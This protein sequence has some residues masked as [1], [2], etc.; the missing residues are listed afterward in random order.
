MGNLVKFYHKEYCDDGVSKL[1]L[2]FV[3][4][5]KLTEISLEILD[6]DS[7]GNI[8]MLA[9]CCPYSKSKYN[10]IHML[11]IDNNINEVTK[12]LKVMYCFQ[13][14]DEG[15]ERLLSDGVIGISLNSAVKFSIEKCYGYNNIYPDLGNMDCLSGYKNNV[16]WES[17]RNYGLDHTNCFRAGCQWEKSKGFL[18]NF[19]PTAKMNIMSMSAD[20][21]V[22]AIGIEDEKSNKHQIEV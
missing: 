17:W 8:K 7:T 11:R 12:I 19:L 2:P 3:P 4:D 16:S 15:L 13:H 22:I 10:I 5:N 6:I 1:W 18:N 9:S 21:S 20:D 14:L